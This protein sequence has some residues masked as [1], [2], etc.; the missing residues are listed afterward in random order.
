MKKLRLGWLCLCLVLL[1]LPV[2]AMPWSGASGGDSGDEPVPFPALTA[3]EGGLNAGFAQQFEDWLCH[4]F[5]FRE[6]LVRLNALLN[7]RLL[8]TS[9]NDQ[10][11]V[12]K[13]GFLYYADTLPDYTGEGRLSPEELA[14][15]GEHLSLLAQGLEEQ[16]AHLYVAIAPNK[17]TIYPDGMPD[18]YPRDPGAGNIRLLEA[19]CRDL[20][21]TWVDLVTPLEEAARQGQVYYRTDTHWNQLGAYAA[22]RAILDATGAGP[23]VP[24]SAAGEAQYAQGDLARLM[25]LTGALGESAPCLTPQEPL[26][27][28]DYSQRYVRVEGQGQGALLVLRDSFGTGVAPYLAQAY[29][30]SAFRWEIPFEVVPP[31]D[32]VVLLIAQR[33]LREYLLEAPI[34]P[35][36]DA[37][38]QSG[39]GEE[40]ENEEDDYEMLR[41]MR[42]EMKEEMDGL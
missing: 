18:P 2:L 23:I 10:V 26:P 14:L 13:N 4:R 7:Y 40:W 28:A 39:G 22:A 33:N 20:P 19:V 15:M 3:P 24:C 11:I 21:L 31:C 37:W 5:A 6:P 17:A 34:L 8:A 42:M 41:R 16:G 25:G 27:Q 35:E 12:G 38:A 36:P 30:E 32:D 29:G 1:T 9:P